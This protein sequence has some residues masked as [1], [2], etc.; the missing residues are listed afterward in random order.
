MIQLSSTM[1]CADNYDSV[2]ADGFIHKNNFSI[3]QFELL[4]ITLDFKTCVI[5]NP[6]VLLCRRSDSMMLIQ[7]N[8]HFNISKVSSEDDLKRIISEI[9]ENL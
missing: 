5:G 6:K 3:D 1:P 2:Q 7:S 4:L 9:N 8:G